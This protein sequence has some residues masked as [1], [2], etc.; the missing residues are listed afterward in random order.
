MTKQSQSPTRVQKPVG[1]PYPHS[2]GASSGVYYEQDELQA[3]MQSQ[4]KIEKW[5]FPVDTSAVE[6]Q[7][8]DAEIQ[9]L[10]NEGRY[11]LSNG[12]LAPLGMKEIAARMAKQ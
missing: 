9:R 12:F 4:L 11:R 2:R 3:I 8:T 10:Q 7:K 6:M 5:M 1:M